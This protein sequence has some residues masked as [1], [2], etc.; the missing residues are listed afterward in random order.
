MAEGRWAKGWRTPLT[1]RERRQ[2]K[3][4]TPMH[5]TYRQ[6]D[7]DPGIVRGSVD[8]AA[9]PDGVTP[10]YHGRGWGGAAA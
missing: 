9:T 8:P 6:D 1:L 3:G 7:A 4:R 10:A 2:F 5:E